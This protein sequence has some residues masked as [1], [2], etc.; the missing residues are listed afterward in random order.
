M[1]YRPELDLV[2][3]NLNLTIVSQLN[4]TSGDMKANWLIR[5]H[6]RKSVFVAGRVP[7]NH[8]YV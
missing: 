6:G 2:L 3:R 8:R 7:E 4:L 5:T 1:R